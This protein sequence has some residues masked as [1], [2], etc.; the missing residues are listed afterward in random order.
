[1]HRGM[2]RWFGPVERVEYERLTKRYTMRKRVKEEA[3][4]DSDKLTKTKSNEYCL[5]VRLKVL[6]T[7]VNV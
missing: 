1:M 6:V 7:G 2:L 3:A 5:M 4:D